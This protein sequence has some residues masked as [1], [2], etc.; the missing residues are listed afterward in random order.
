MC[1]STKGEHLAPLPGLIEGENGCLLGP[2]AICTRLIQYVGCRA[3]GQWMPVEDGASGMQFMPFTP[4]E[5]TRLIGEGSPICSVV[6]VPFRWL[7]LSSVF[8]GSGRYGIAM[9]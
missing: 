6:I 5:P 2:A 4:S 1:L 7:C 9:L 3:G 8:E